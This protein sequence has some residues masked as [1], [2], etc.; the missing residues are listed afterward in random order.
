LLIMK[1]YHLDQESNYQILPAIPLFASFPFS[2]LISFAMIE[3][4]IT[5]NTRFCDIELWLKE[6]QPIY[7][8]CRP[9]SLKDLNA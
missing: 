1:N 5:I 9:S 6:Q 4:G 2:K 7:L 3:M 8:N